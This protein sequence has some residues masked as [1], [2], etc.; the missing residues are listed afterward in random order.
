MANTARKS[1]STSM[2]SPIADQARFI[3]GIRE[4]VQQSTIIQAKGNLSIDKNQTLCLQTKSRH[5]QY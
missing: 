4:N 2:H 3:Q 5:S 1:H